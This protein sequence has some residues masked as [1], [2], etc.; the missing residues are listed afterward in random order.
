MALGL[1]HGFGPLGSRPGFALD[2]GAFL[3]PGEQFDAFVMGAERHPQ[4]L[5]EG[6][7]LRL[8]QRCR[9]VGVSDMAA[10]T[11]QRSVLD[12]HKGAAAIG[13]AERGRLAREELSLCSS[14]IAI[15]SCSAICAS[16]SMSSGMETRGPA[17][18]WLK[19]TIRVESASSGRQK[20]TGTFCIRVAGHVR[21]GGIVG[22]LDDGDAAA[23]LDGHQAGRPVIREVPVST[24]PTTR[25]P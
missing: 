6:V 7:S 20:S 9:A 25:G 17:G 3:H 4:G 5:L 15:I 12:F 23:A 10:E 1:V 18:S 14:I 2:L 8:D 24:M 21:P 22:V 13:A 16:N 11:Q 19:R